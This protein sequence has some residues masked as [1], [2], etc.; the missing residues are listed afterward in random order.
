MANMTCWKKKGKL[1][2]MY[3]LHICGNSLSL[4]GCIWSMG[5]WWSFTVFI[6]LIKWDSSRNGSFQHHI[7]EFFKCQFEHFS[8]Y[9]YI[10]FF[11]ITY[12][13]YSHTVKIHSFSKKIVIWTDFFR[14]YSITYRKAQY[15]GKWDFLVL[16]QFSLWRDL[17]RRGR[18]ISYSV[19]HFPYLFFIV[20]LVRDRK[21]M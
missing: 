19:E 20:N 13:Q 11:I 9:I 18:W 10:F 15:I 16:F 8:V 6:C 21:K 4:E 3:Q 1:N 7:L 17:R 14:S 5:L 12:L 2:C